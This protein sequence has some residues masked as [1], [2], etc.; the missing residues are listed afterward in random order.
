MCVFVCVCVCA[1]VSK[2]ELLPVCLSELVLPSPVIIVVI[3]FRSPALAAHHCWWF[4]R[5]REK[6]R[7]SVITIL[8]IYCQERKLESNSSKRQLGGHIWECKIDLPLLPSHPGSL[9]KALLL[10]P[11]PQPEV[12]FLTEYLRKLEEKGGWGGLETETAFFPGISFMGM[13]SRQERIQKDIDIV[14]QK[15]KAEKDCLF[16]DFRY[17]DSTFT[18]TYVGGTKRTQ[19]AEDSLFPIL[20]SPLNL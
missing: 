7:L 15:S 9:R 6:V 1:R 20:N 16:A 13:C 19:E 12:S 18:F 4:R 17:S 8:W 10:H 5:G 2:N 14:I 3:I 11:L